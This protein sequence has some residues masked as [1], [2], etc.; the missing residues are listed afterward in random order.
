MEF[1]VLGFMG[2]SGSGKDF[3]S[4]WVIDNKNFCKVSFAD[5]IKRLCKMVF[6]FSDEQ[7]WGEPE[8]R[9]VKIIPGNPDSIPSSSFAHEREQYWDYAQRDL[10]LCVHDWVK[11]LALTAEERARYVAVVIDWFL[12]CRK[13]AGLTLSSPDKVIQQEDVG[14]ISARVALQLLGTEFGRHF[15]DTIWLDTLY[16]KTADW[17]KQGYAYD[18][19]KGVIHD[20]EGE[21]N[22]IIVNDHRFINELKGSQA[23]G[24]YVIKLIRLAHENKANAAEE[25]GIKG[26]ASEAEQRGI[27]EGD[28]DLVLRMEDGAENVYGR[29]EKMFDGREWLSGCD[30]DG[31]SAG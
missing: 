2:E 11:T 3:C 19:V 8:S 18:R 1:F 23:Q 5:P 25:A 13:R 28:Y 29:L 30:S 26:H 17:I 31:P 21:Y 12:E 6:G 4:Q 20:E 7:L 22:G 24:G 9:A 15:K 16:E 27:A 14:V 10:Q